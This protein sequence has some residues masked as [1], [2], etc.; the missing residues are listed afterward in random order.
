MKQTSYH[1]V[2]AFQTQSKEGF[3]PL[4]GVGYADISLKNFYFCIKSK[5]I[6][7]GVLKDGRVQR[8]KP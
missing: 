7:Y 2:F 6:Y 3:S 8:T 1:W 5:V 4:S